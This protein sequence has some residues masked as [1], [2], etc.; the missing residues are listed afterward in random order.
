MSVFT[1]QP[2]VLLFCSRFL[3]HRGGDIFRN[4]KEKLAYEAF[5]LETQT[6]PNCVKHGEAIYDA[7]EEYTHNTIYKFERI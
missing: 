3:A 7:G 2:C 4:C 6:E 1:D 5:C